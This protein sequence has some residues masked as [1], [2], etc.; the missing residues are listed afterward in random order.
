[1]SHWSVA[2][3]GVKGIS[4][5]FFLEKYVIARPFS[6]FNTAAVGKVMTMKSTSVLAFET[7]S[8]LT[9]SITVE[10]QLVA[11]ASKV[12]EGAKKLQFCHHLSALHGIG[13]K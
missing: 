10:G 4:Q 5:K 2:V 7:N 6:L 13:T 1:M 3:N 8:T 9:H 11:E 12:T